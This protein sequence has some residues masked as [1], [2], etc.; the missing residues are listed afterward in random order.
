MQ[1][2]VSAFRDHMLPLAEEFFKK[3]K[4]V[5]CKICTSKKTTEKKKTEKKRDTAHLNSLQHIWREHIHASINFIGNIFLRLFYK[6]L[7]LS[8]LWL[9]NHNTIFRGLIHFCD[10]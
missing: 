10:L 5:C 4:K 9:I 1:D 8:I 7:N 2:N 6:V 3:E